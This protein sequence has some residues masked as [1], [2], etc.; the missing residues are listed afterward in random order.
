MSRRTRWEETEDFSIPQTPLIDIIFILIIFFLVSTTF[1]TE[2]RDLKVKLPDGTEG[3]LIEKQDK[4]FVINVR[5]NGISVVNNEVL[6]LDAL[7]KQLIEREKA[8]Q[9][10]AEIRGDTETPHGKIMAVMNL[11]K[12]HNIGN[13][14]ITQR[15]IR[16]QQ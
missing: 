12:K 1:Y 4:H 8:G 10:Q 13:L 16:Q 11:C 7:E 9:H 2:E 14:A 3:N 6:S 5:G 15:I